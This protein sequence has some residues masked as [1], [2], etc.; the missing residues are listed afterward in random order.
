MTKAE[1][2]NMIVDKTGAT[3]KDAAD[4]FEA[5]FTTISESLGNGEKVAI[6]GFGSFDISERA[7]R[8]GRNPQ[9]GE[10]IDIAASKNVRFKATSALKEKVN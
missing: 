3:K 1:L 7:A 8:K 5:V 6:A 2:I 4:I 9:T 10:E